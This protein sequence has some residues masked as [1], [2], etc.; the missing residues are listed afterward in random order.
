MIRA[1]RSLPWT[2][3]AF[4]SLVFAEHALASDWIVPA[5]QT[6]LVETPKTG[7]P[8]TVDNL[9]IEPGATLRVVG[10]T[11]FYVR[12]TGRIRID[13]RLD[14]SGAGYPADPNV[15]VATLQTT[16]LPEPGFIGSAA[17]GSGGAGN[18]LIGASCPK[19]G[20]GAGSFGVPQGGGKGGE[21]GYNPSADD[22][23]RRP[24]GGGGGAYA[25][26]QPVHPDPAHPS[27]IGL[28]ARPG[29]DGAPTAF[30]ALTG[31]LIPKGGAI[32]ELP[33]QDGNPRNDF[34][35]RKLDPLSGHVIFGELLSP[36]GGR[37]GGGGGNAIQSSVFPGAW[38]PTG[39]ERGAGG[40]GG[41]GLAILVAREIVIGQQ[42]RIQ[43]NG[44]NGGAGEN[45][46][47]GGGNTHIAGGSGGGSGGQVILQA[48]VIDLHAAQP[49]ALTA[50]GGRG[51]AGKN[52]VFGAECAG[53][54]GG[55]G[56]IQLHTS[57]GLSAILLPPGIP[58]SS[59]TSPDA[60]VLLPEEGDFLL[61]IPQ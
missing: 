30:G 49:N 37:G 45:S 51:G 25:P 13:G 47:T 20:D 61:L 40:G 57:G 4:A 46:F 48:Q 23:L 11:R 6:V 44:G 12:A 53:G 9:I 3:P 1:L 38:T 34:Y 54:D 58:L 42:G 39:D 22:A 32:G 31:V 18:P 43:A 56:I 17:G 7:H 5:G 10:S 36:M 60:H 15:G 8:D 35:G 41:G 55:P 26:N 16:F 14:L 52:A 2:L 28:I 50:L 33:F 19:G 27:N 21:S 59:M 24:G 29:H